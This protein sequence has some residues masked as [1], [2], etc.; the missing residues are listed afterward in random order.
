MEESTRQA[1]NEKTQDVIDAAARAAALTAGQAAAANAI[2]STDI[3]Y[4]KRDIAEIKQSFKEITGVFATQA[5]V[6]ELTEMVN[7]R[8]HKLENN[9]F[10]KWVLPGFAAFMAVL[11]DN[12][13]TFYLS[14]QK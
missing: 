1:M 4:I 12:L 14:H 6:I 8:F 2:V 7:R 13:I 10:Y 9:N 3:G 11:L 5:S